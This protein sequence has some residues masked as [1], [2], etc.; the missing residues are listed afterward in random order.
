MA[1]R[2][3]KRPGSGLPKGFK[4]PETIKKEEAKKQMQN[5]II[6][7]LRPLL[8]AQSSLARGV[9]YV[10]QII[11]E[12]DDKGKITRREHVQLKGADEIRH[13]LDVLEG[14][15]EAGDNEYYYITSE[16]PDLRAIDSMLDR[17]FGRAT[18]S[19]EIDNPKD[20]EELKQIND[21]LK[22]MFHNVKSKKAIKKN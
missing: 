7:Q 12:K 20:N 16:K 17:V 4:F 9:Q 2:G 15:S 1:K 13:A 18:Q 21:T 22:E 6:A 3:G 10:Y 19:M 8:S 14:L 5:Y 11:T